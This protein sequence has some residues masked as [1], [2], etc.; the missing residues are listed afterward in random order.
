MLF[1]V[2]REPRYLTLP[3]RSM[4]QVVEASTAKQAVRKAVFKKD[5]EYS[6]P[7]AIPLVLD[8]VNYI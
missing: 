2:I 8:L 7:Y 3:L 1:I 6:A 4:F 5:R